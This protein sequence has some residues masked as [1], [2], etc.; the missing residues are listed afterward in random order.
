MQPAYERASVTVGAHRPLHADQVHREFTGPNAR[1]VALRFVAR[2]VE[3]RAE[4]VLAD[5]DA[6]RIR[7]SMY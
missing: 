7:Q 3:L 4:T 6:Q 5:V 2:W 1:S